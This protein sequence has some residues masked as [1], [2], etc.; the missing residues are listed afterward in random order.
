MSQRIAIVDYGMGNLRSVQK[1]FAHVAPGDHV[2]ITA[3]PEAVAPPR[4]APTVRVPRAPPRASPVA[5]GDHG[6]RSL[7]GVNPYER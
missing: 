7:D 3:D 1:A 2:E 6:K 4:A 5:N